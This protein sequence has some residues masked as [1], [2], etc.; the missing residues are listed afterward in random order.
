[1]VLSPLLVV[2]VLLQGL[3]SLGMLN[4]T[5]YGQVRLAELAVWFTGLALVGGVYMVVTLAFAWLGVQIFAWVLGLF[6]PNIHTAR[7]HLVEWMKQFYEAVGDEFKPFG[8]TARVV[9]VE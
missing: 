3:G 2:P 7:L 4:T 1:M 5:L 8:F 9:E 6:S